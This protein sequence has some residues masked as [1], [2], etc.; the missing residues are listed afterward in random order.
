M[1]T[2]C[3]PR[4]IERDNVPSARSD[5]ALDTDLLK[6]HQVH[7]CADQSLLVSQASTKK[8]KKRENILL[9]LPLSTMQQVHRLYFQIV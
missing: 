4:I 5:A 7:V 2:V 3:S 8:K 1:R 9:D 6:N